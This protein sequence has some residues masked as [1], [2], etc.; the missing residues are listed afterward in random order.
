MSITT[1]VDIKLSKLYFY[2]R[3]LQL[4]KSWAIRFQTTILQNIVSQFIIVWDIHRPSFLISYPLNTYSDESGSSSYKEKDPP[5]SALFIDICI[6]TMS[7]ILVSLGSFR[8]DLVVPG[9]LHYWEM[10][11]SNSHKSMSLQPF[12]LAKI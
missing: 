1:P 10:N 6:Y 7:M 8:R 3:L 11:T 9:H 5:G 12:S 4:T 2:V